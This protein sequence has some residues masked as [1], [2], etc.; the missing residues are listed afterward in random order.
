MADYACTLRQAVR[1]FPLPAALA[2]I[3]ARADRLGHHDG[4]SF[5]DRAYAR[6]SNRA[7]C[8]LASRYAIGQK[9]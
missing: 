9:V 4:P 3:A 6:A 7:R 5:A 1:E 2:L 8:W